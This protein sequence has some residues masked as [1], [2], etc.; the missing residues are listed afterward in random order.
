MLAVVF[1]EFIIFIENWSLLIEASKG[2]DS[3]VLAFEHRV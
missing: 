2:D 1:K 3:P